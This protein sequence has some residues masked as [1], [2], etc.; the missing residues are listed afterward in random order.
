[1]RATTAVS[2][3][4]QLYRDFWARFLDR[5]HEERPGW[6]NARI[7]STDNWMTMP[8]PLPHCQ[9]GAN[10]TRTHVRTE[11]YV[12]SGEA[13]STRLVYDAL[14]EHRADIEAL[15]GGSLEWEPLPDR[16]ACRIAAYTPGDVTQADQHEAYIDWL[17]DTGTRLRHALAPHRQA[18]LDALNAAR[19]HPDL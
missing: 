6:T 8:A 5:V 14:S 16:R 3:K 17:I 7:P 19:P 2:G 13:D 12:D 11:L 4:A 9:T 10:F 1:M 15:Y 18:V